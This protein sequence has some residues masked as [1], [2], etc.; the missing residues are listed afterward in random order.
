MASHSS[1]S[2]PYDHHTSLPPL[3]TSGENLKLDR[4]SSP[5][6]NKNVFSSFGIPSLTESPMDDSLAYRI[7]ALP[8]YPDDRNH[9]RPS[10]ATSERPASSAAT[11]L[12]SVASRA[13]QF[14]FSVQPPKRFTPSLT[15]NES[16]V[17]SPNT[18][19]AQFYG[20]RANLK[21][22]STSSLSVVEDASSHKS[23]SSKLSKGKLYLRNPLSLLARRRSSQN[24]P[25][26]GEE[27]NL[28]VS[29]LNVPDLPDDYDPRIR[30][31]IVHDFSIPKARRLNSYTG[32]SSAETSPSIGSRPSTQFQ[33]RA[34]EQLP[35]VGSL[36]PRTPQSPAQSPLCNEHFDDD[37]DDDDTESL[38][39][40]ST[41]HLHTLASP[42]ATRTG[43]E[44]PK[45]PEFAKFLPLDIF[46]EVDSEE[47]VSPITA[48]KNSTSK[49]EAIPQLSVRGLEATNSFLT[50]SSS[51]TSVLTTDKELE[52]GSDFLRPL[53]N[54]PKHKTS[55]SSR[56]S[57]Q[58]IG[59]DSEAQERLLEERHKQ[60]AISK[61]L[62][63]DNREDTDSQED[64]YADHD[65]E[66]DDGL[67]EKIPGVNADLDDELDGLSQIKDE[68]PDAD[69]D[70]D[71][72]LDE[73]IPGIDAELE[74]LDRYQDG[75]SDADFNDD[76]DEELEEKIPGINAE[77]D[78]EVEEYPQHQLL[79]AF[80]FIPSSARI[81]PSTLATS[82]HL[83]PRDGEGEVNGLA[84]TKVSPIP[85]SIPPSL[86]FGPEAHERLP[87]LGG[88]GITS[89]DHQGSAEGAGIPQQPPSQIEEPQ[90]D[91]DDMYFHDGNIEVSDDVAGGETFDE[92]IF[93]AE[94]GSIYDIPAQNARKLEFAQQQN[95]VRLSEPGSFP[96]WHNTAGLDKSHQESIPF[97]STGLEVS[98]DTFG[99]QYQQQEYD[100]LDDSQP[101]G[102]TEDNLAYQNAL[103][104][105]A[106]QAAAQ[107]R[108]SRHL[109]MS[110]DSEDL[111]CKS[112]IT[113]SQPGLISD[114]S[115]ISHF[116]D[117]AIAEDEPDELLVDDSLEDD[118]MIAEANAEVLENDDDGFY[119]QEFGFYA[120]AHGKGH[121]EMVNG[122]FFGPK[123][124]EGVHRSHSAK[125]NFQEPSLTPITERSEWSHRNSFASVHT[126]GLPAARPVVVGPYIVQMPD[127]DPPTYEDDMSLSALLKLRRD[128]WG[129]SQT[130]LHSTGAGQSGSSP[131]SHPPLRDSY[132]SQLAATDS[133]PHSGNDSA[134]LS[135]DFTASLP[136]VFEEDGS[137]QGSNAAETPMAGQKILSNAGSHTPLADVRVH[138]GNPSQTSQALGKASKCHSRASSGGESVSY[139]KD[140]EGSGRW[141]LER[142]R[143][144]EDGEMELVEREYVAGARI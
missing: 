78:E 110:H 95:L 55:A 50:H 140:P 8:R 64:Q 40:Q 116:L 51:A 1:S 19:P 134:R 2:H 138:S 61:M 89:I 36:G 38:Q 75:Y 7:T 82:S 112:Q 71:D 136:E 132:G 5:A 86:E 13:H 105:A 17:T 70:G 87:L 11:T 118:A 144:G 122:G 141:L 66:D 129:G 96:Q 22:V 49:L 92:A 43:N 32:L 41:G 52:P 125:A 104:T 127:L 12:A 23:A 114:D 133:R 28:S 26:K 93:D 37:D 99:K 131:L 106:N 44:S 102:L 59:T 31:K 39:P 60:H 4:P 48:D 128:T 9:H 68:Y 30:G 135:F 91:T 10:S 80:H 72:G 57:F 35:Q 126:L 63:A 54:L 84:N 107:G 124:V 83:T 108:F 121:S 117:N 119:G 21:N 46:C 139:M 34:S 76:D 97:S 69:F 123:G 65:F 29:T 56:F 62:P 18:G 77:L 45:L 24:Q 67:E 109:S 115:R 120:H 130:S 85:R 111:N 16:P 143:T 79:E 94:D 3:Q 100:I 42:S 58:L 98:N 6:A 88:L 14:V 27:G 101:N 33:R 53:E 137:N 81:S 90:E 103:V 25:I 47:A 74:G 142:R 113:E 20:D 15:P 73:Q